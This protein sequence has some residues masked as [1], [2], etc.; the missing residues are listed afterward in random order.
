MLDLKEENKNDIE[1]INEIIDYCK[2]NNKPII[3]WGM[4]QN[5]FYD[6][7][8]NIF[9]IKDYVD[10]FSKMQNAL[11]KTDSEKEKEK[12]E[13]Y[14]IKR[15]LTKKFS[16][17]DERIFQ[18][19]GAI[20]NPVQRAKEWDFITHGI[21]FDLKSTRLFD[22]KTYLK[23]KIMSKSLTNEEL[24]YLGK[25]FYTRQSGYKKKNG[26]FS[27]NNRLFLVHISNMEN[28]MMRPDDAVKLKFTDKA[29]AIKYFM[30][31]DKIS[32]HTYKD[33]SSG[34]EALFT[35]LFFCEDENGNVTWYNA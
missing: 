10:F 17:I 26:R 34:E 11:N 28:D 27:I 33:D 4:V 2:K 8:L 6:R 12:R 32:T 16:D 29:H 24:E 5:V 23:D 30:S 18:H 13:Q 31:L 9:K 14:F 25:E 20:P 19:Y 22:D 1:I 3:N 7:L 15:C 35:F 21:K